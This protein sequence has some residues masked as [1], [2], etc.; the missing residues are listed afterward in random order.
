MFYEMSG[1]WKVNIKNK[2]FAINFGE[3]LPDIVYDRKGKFYAFLSEEA[4][5]I[6]N[7]I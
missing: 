3:G 6:I 1:K 5:D 7:W 4:L 2:C